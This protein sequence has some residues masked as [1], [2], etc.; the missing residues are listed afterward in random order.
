[1]NRRPA[2]HATD[3]PSPAIRAVLFDLHQTLVDGG[4]AVRWVELAWN[5]LGRAGRIEL[6]DGVAVA[7]LA[8][9]LDDV[10]SHA[11]TIDPT[12][13]RDLDGDTHRRVFVQT[14]AAAP[15]TDPELTSALYTTMPAAL[16]AY[17]DARPVLTSLRD[18]GIRTAVLSNIGFDVRPLLERDGLAPLLDAVVLSFE[19]GVKKPGAVIFEHALTRLEVAPDETLMVGDSWRDDAG[20][21]AL[22]I[23]TLL[24]PRTRGPVHG[25]DAVRRLVG[26]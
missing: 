7:D 25:L 15:G 23:R 13:E 2:V 12:S 3:A 22:G 16:T 14:V 4:D 17:A 11:R 5:H 8:A 19:V 10:W 20:A 1:V 9:W 18:A 24:L 21:A 26:C 6:R